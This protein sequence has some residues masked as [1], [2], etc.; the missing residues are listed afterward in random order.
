M[1][2]M[3]AEIGRNLGEGRP[4]WCGLKQEGG[5]KETGSASLG[6]PI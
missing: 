5:G 3:R 2:I 4:E 6:P 1:P